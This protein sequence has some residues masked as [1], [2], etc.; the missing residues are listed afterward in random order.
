MTSPKGIM[1]PKERALRVHLDSGSEKNL[2]C[3]HKFVS[4]VSGNSPESEPKAHKA[5]TNGRIQSPRLKVLFTPY[6]SSLA[7]V[8]P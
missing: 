1:S 4:P 3:H 5:S 8:Q 2:K 7:L 6:L